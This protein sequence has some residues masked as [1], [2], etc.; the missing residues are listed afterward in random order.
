[1]E[2]RALFLLPLCFPGRRRARRVPG[3]RD[4][5]PHFLLPGELLQHQPGCDLGRAGRE[6]QPQ[7]PAHSPGSSRLLGWS[8]L[9]VQRG[10]ISQ[11]AFPTTLA[12]LSSSD[13]S[14]GSGQCPEHLLSLTSPAESTKLPAHG[15]LGRNLQPAQ[16]QSRDLLASL[17]MWQEGA[18]SLPWLLPSAPSHHPRQSPWLGWGQGWAPFACR[19]EQTP[20]DSCRHCATHGLRAQH[21]EHPVLS[22]GFDPRLQPQLKAQHC[23]PHFQAGEFSTGKGFWG[24]VL[25]QPPVSPGE[26]WSRVSLCPLGGCEQPCTSQKG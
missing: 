24:L 9:G 11:S 18:A 14:P 13:G 7:F 4:D 20:G 19:E 23:P 3:D 5:L 25:F 6:G 21:L 10:S 15:G 16:P 26:G 8:V 17:G 22:V 1:M 2:L 12:L